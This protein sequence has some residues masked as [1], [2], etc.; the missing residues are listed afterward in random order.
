MNPNSGMN[1]LDRYEVAVVG[2]GPAG[3]LLAAR[4]AGAGVC[5]LVVE[6]SDFNEQRPGEFLTP[7]ARVALN[8]SGSLPEAWE[9][10][11]RIVH[12]F[13]GTWGSDSGFARNFI[14]DAHGHALILDRAAFDR[15]LANMAVMR[16]ATLL[17]RARVCGAE[18]TLDG[19]IVDVRRGSER[20]AVRA[21]FLALCSGRAGP[22]IRSI[23]ARRRP[24]DRLVCLGMR[25]RRCP[26]AY[27]PSIE[28]Y[29]RGWV[30]SAASVGGELVVNVCTE[31][32]GEHRRP[33][34]S[35]DLLFEELAQCPIASAR[36]L[37]CDATKGDVSFFAVD[38][39]SGVAR[40]AAGP[41]WCLAGD[42][43]QSV[44]PLSSNG[45]AHALRHAELI[46]EAIRRSR[47]IGDCDL[48]EY[49]VWLDQN[50]R[51]YSRSH[52]YYYG[53]ETRWQSPFWAERQKTGLEEN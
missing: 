46:F 1:P 43:A 34:R 16:G 5:V 21:S 15:E 11:H 17:T 7:Q 29:A 3:S 31:L 14:F 4:L 44:D 8:A 28:S 13:T 35:P 41:G 12:E 32:K 19:W 49:C 33:V 37:E 10:Q 45:I 38:A 2:A 36:V 22:S 53:L 24:L 50:Y 9:L 27:A 40:P 20:F 39:S 30:Y 18:R 26:E 47:S 51:E 52:R 25:M 48:R 42:C 6:S 23:P